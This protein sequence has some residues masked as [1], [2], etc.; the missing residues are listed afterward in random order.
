MK[1]VLFASLVA[2]AVL[3]GTAS[4]ALAQTPA[5]SGGLQISEVNNGWVVAPEV[6]FTTINDRSAT[7]AGGYVGY[8]I[9]HTVLIGG[10]AYGLTNRD[11]NFEAQYGG[12]LV[13]W[14]FGGDRPI[15][16][17]A[18]A[19]IGGGSAT[20][21]R[22]YADLIGRPGAGPA[23]NRVSGSTRVRV[24]DDFF[25]AE[26]KLNLLV[27]LTAWMRLDIGGSYRA[28]AGSRLLEG[29]LRGASGSVGIRFGSH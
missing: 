6:Q 15:A 5:S 10:A 29:Q 2:T 11:R 22:T 1:A 18:G 23:A 3:V 12:G 27:R 19:L 17:S 8:D 21:T 16:I 9:E 14:T 28:V 7:L 13:R 4:P 26:P 24:H 20:L 25:V